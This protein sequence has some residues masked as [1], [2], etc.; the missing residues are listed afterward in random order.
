MAVIATGTYTIVDL[1]DPIQQG[2]APVS[3]VISMLW[4]DTSLVPNLLK[5]WNGTTWDIVNDTS[6]LASRVTD[7][8]LLITDEAIVATVRSS[9]DYY[10]DMLAKVSTTAYNTQ[11]GVLE[12]AIALKTDLTTTSG[13]DVRVSTAEQQLIPTSI[14]STVRTS[15]EYRID[16]QNVTTEIGAMQT[17]LGA[18]IE[19]ADIEDM[20]TSAYVQETIA[21]EITQRDDA[22]AM[23]V[24]Q[25][26]TRAEAVEG[27]I[28]TFTDIAKTYFEFLLDGL[29]IGKFGSDFAT[30]L[31]DDKLSFMQGGTEVAYIQY[32]K[33]YISAAEVID[34]LTIGN[35]DPQKGPVVGFTDI[36]TG[37]NGVSAVWRAN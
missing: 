18:K 9:T 17:A 3:P 36:K 27:Q 29:R 35:T 26:R 31:G 20:A 6:T 32:N 30:L 2:T 1:Y 19:A 15:E 24:S 34:I 11:I 5:R 25:E 7:A 4:L 12:D 13:L 8:E 21:T 10:N 14:I 23:V 22:I 33:L 37:S 16:F 28:K